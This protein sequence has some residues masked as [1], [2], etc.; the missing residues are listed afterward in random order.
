MRRWCDEGGGGGGREGGRFSVMMKLLMIIKVN[1]FE[2]DHEIV[3]LS[4]NPIRKCLWHP[5]ALCMAEIP[6]SSILMDIIFD[7]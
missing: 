2:F 7:S 6:K 1:L 3:I 5:S 4:N